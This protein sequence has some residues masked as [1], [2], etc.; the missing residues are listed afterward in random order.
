MGNCTG[1]CISEA[2]NN[3]M[4][5]TVEQGY[6][7]VDSVRKNQDG[8]SQQPTEFE[9]EYGNQTKAKVIKDYK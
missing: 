5:V 7:N 3:K 4:K 6:Y 2:E 8:L 9:I 1:Y